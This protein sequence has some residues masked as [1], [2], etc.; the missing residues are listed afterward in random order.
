MLYHA[1]RALLS[2]IMLISFIFLAAIPTVAQESNYEF[3]KHDYAKNPLE[4]SKS[5]A[6]KQTPKADPNSASQPLV[7][8]VTP[9]SN[10]IPGIEPSGKAIVSISLI[11]SNLDFK[12]L[13]TSLEALLRI[14]NEKS[15]RTSTLYL[16]GLPSEHYPEEL[17]TMFSRLSMLGAKQSLSEEPPAN[18][19]VNTVPSWIVTTNEGDVVLEGL[20][21][22]ERFIN[23]KGEFI[24]PKD[25]VSDDEESI[26]AKPETEPTIT[27]TVVQTEE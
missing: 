5:S 22:P 6:G 4:D 23:S 8:G 14:Y 15:V 19:K 27:P 16:L 24:D 2:G 17:R 13:K 25:V 26:E 21:S 18:F 12:S 11:V 1:K 7:E 20:S 10:I 3:Y 9:G